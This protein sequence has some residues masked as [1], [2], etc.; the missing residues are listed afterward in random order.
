MERKRGSRRRFKNLTT[1]FL[2]LIIVVFFSCNEV[3]K[4]E[5]TTEIKE[6]VVEKT[7][8]DKTSSKEKIKKDTL[9]YDIIA[10]GYF[11][12]NEVK[13]T[14][15]CIFINDSQTGE[16]L[17]N[18][19]V[20][21]EKKVKEITIPVTTKD[22]QI[23]NCKQGCIETVESIIGENAYDET[24][25]YMYDEKLED[26]FIIE[27]TIFEDGEEKVIKPKKIWNISM[28]KSK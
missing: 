21:L 5:K 2:L 7:K 28:T 23:N 4:P 11:D 25:S 26:W 1:S 16:P 3:K 19:K 14:I 10:T 27:T 24:I 22:I 20:F 6:T 18:C 17:Y 13:D 8:V 15:K 12:I 9:L